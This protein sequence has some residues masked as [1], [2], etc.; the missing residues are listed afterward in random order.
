MIVLMVLLGAVRGALHDD[1]HVQ[2][3]VPIVL[4]LCRSRRS[5]RPSW[6]SLE[7]GEMEDVVDRSQPAHGTASEIGDWERR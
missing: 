1:V 7:Q 3:V 6:R 2:L 4:A 5:E